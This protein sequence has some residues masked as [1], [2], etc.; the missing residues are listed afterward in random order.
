[1]SVKS[2]ITIDIL[3]SIKKTCNNPTHNIM[4]SLKIIINHITKTCKEMKFH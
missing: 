2:F 1:M 3:T 4:G